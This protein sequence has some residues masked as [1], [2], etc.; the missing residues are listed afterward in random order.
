MAPRRTAGFHARMRPRYVPA[1]RAP[2]L[3]S[4]HLSRRR[5][6]RMQARFYR[7]LV[8]GAGGMAMLAYLLW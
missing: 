8:M 4:R 5:L 3:P 1:R 6:Q 2:G 7:G